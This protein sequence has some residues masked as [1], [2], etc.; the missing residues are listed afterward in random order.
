MPSSTTPNKPVIGVAILC[1]LFF[2]LDPS[3]RVKADPVTYTVSGTGS[4][5]LVTVLGGGHFVTNLFSDAFLSM[6]ATA[7]TE[8][9]TNPLPGVFKVLNSTWNLSV[10]QLGSAR[11][12]TP[13]GTLE[14]QKSSFNLSLAGVGAPEL[15]LV[16]L[17][18]ADPALAS[19]DLSTSIGPITGTPLFNPS[20]QFPVYIGFYDGYFSLTSVSSASFQAVVQSVPEPSSFTLLGISGFSICFRLMRKIKDQKI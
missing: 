3:A 14:N 4:G 7:D 20:A 1:G 17:A 10:D 19:Y 18:V 9:I 6:V 11:F 12:A 5:S 13:I 16:I 8:Q 15:N 2:V